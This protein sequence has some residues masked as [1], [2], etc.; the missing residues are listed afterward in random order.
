[1]SFTYID[2]CVMDNK[3]VPNYFDKMSYL[4]DFWCMCWDEKFVDQT[5]I[6]EDC[7]RCPDIVQRSCLALCD[8]LRSKDTENKEKI[9][10]N[11]IDLTKEH[12]RFLFSNKKH[13]WE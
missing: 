3:T 8:L 5:N 1:M 13:D 9:I 6:K 4:Q 7:K 11:F 12:I 10:I 2:I